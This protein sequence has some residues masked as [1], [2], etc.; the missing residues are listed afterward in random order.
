MSLPSIRGIVTGALADFGSWIGTNVSR[1]LKAWALERNLGLGSAI[2][3][4]QNTMKE[5][6][7]QLSD[8]QDVLWRLR[9]SMSTDARDW[10]TGRLDA[11]LYGILVGWDP[12]ALDGVAKRHH[13]DQ[14]GRDRLLAM[15]WVVSNFIG[16]RKW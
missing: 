8:L 16:D 6:V 12:Q 4:W 10:S 3:P 7:R 15:H 2:A 1:D 11:W 5:F 14:A 9:S 13:W